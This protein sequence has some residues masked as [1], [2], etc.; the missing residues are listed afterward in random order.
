M[1]YLLISSVIFCVQL[2]GIQSGKLIAEIPEASG[3]GYCNNSDTLIVANDEGTYYEITTDGKILIK[4]KLGNFDLEGVVCEETQM[5]FAVENRGILI[6]ERKSGQKKNIILNTDYNGKK[7]SLFNKKAGVEGIAKQGD[8]L[9]LSKQSKKKK[10]AFITVIDLSSS[11]HS[12]ID[13]IEHGIPDTSGLSFHE[14]YLYMVS[15]RKDLLIKYDLQKRKIV[16]KIKLGKGAWEGITF[17]NNGFVYLADD[18]GRVI[19]YKKRA[20]DYKKSR[21]FI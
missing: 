19:R 17:D 9:Y 4:K 5:I 16:H 14:G 11:D 21:D 15:D 6:V 3:I 7:I 8:R 20:W 13:V 1:R 2:Y 18:D 12:I 10:N